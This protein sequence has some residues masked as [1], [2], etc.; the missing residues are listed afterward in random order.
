[1]GFVVDKVALAQVFSPEY[2]GFPLSI[3]FH[4]CSINRKRTKNTFLG[5]PRRMPGLVQQNQGSLPSKSLHMTFHESSSTVYD[6]FNPQ[7]VVKSSTNQLRSRVSGKTRP[8]GI[9]PHR[10][11]ILTESP[12]L[13]T[14]QTQ[15][16]YLK[17]DH[18]RFE[19]FTAV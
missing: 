11:Y 8:G 15:Q 1:V 4:R 18:A 5:S 3:S 13:S 12:A 17:Y 2:F 14:F 7:T 16:I 10:Q 6:L 9:I 19:V